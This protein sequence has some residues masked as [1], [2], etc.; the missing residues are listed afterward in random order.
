MTINKGMVDKIMAMLKRFHEE[1]EQQDAVLEEINNR[2][3]HCWNCSGLQMITKHKFLCQVLKA[4]LPNNAVASDYLNLFLTD[5]FCG[6]KARTL[7][8]TEGF[9]YLF[10]RGFACVTWSSAKEP[11]PGDG[12]E[13]EREPGDEVGCACP[14]EIGHIGFW[15]V[16][17][18]GFFL[19]Y[20]D[21]S[22]SCSCSSLQQLTKSY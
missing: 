12:K 21:F 2:K 10:V 16:I 20:F 4:Q 15:R 6:G 22:C 14:V 7:A 8:S 17:S 19:Y 11:E 9:I 5:D 3:M 18:C 13:N 1:A